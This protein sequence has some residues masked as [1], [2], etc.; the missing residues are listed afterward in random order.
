MFSLICRL[1]SSTEI[2]LRNVL[3]L[4][5]FFSVGANSGAEKKEKKKNRLHS[6]KN[7]P[8]CDQEVIVGCQHDTLKKSCH[9]SFFHR[10]H[11]YKFI[12]NWFVSAKNAEN[13]AGTFI[14]SPALPIWF[15]IH[16]EGDSR[17]AELHSFSLHPDNWNK[18]PSETESVC[19][20]YRTAWF[21]SNKLSHQCVPFITANNVA[22]L[23]KTKPV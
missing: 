10:V 9:I 22:A 13:I 2:C 3:G 12:C 23:E 18:C 17:K 1:F 19:L 15:P 5:R 16:S 20:I 14:A 11:I 4:E 8:L 21:W 6:R 7:T